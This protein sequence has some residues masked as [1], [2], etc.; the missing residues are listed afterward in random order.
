MWHHRP[1][2]DQRWQNHATAGE[3]HST[4][5]SIVTP[6]EPGKGEVSLLGPEVKQRKSFIGMLLF[7]LEEAV[8]GFL[9]GDC[10]HLPR[11][12]Q[13]MN[14]PSYKRHVR[15]T[16]QQLGQFQ[17]QNCFVTLVVVADRRYYSPFFQTMVSHESILG[18]AD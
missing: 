7:I 6:K 2:P 9:L 8:L 3:R 17:G 10:C 4:L 13:A 18:S 12:R 1:F 14:C 16:N 5:Q 15:H 11:P